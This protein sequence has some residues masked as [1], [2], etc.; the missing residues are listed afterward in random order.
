MISSLLVIVGLV[1][2]MFEFFLPGA[3]LGILGGISLIAAFVLFVTEYP[4]F[5]LIILFIGGVSCGLYGVIRFALWR[6]VHK[7]GENTFY[8]KSDQEGYVAS[9]YDKNMIG[10]QGIVVADLKPGGYIVVDGKHQSALSTSGYI[11][12]GE[13]VDIIGGQEQSLV[14]KKKLYPRKLKN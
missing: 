13:K 5:P 9:E 10:K 8:L 12:K 2:V 4:S 14:V 6:I 1:L 3:I 11:A 7:K